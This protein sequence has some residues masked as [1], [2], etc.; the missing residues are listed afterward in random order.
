MRRLI[1]NADDLGINPSRD[2]GIFECIERGILTS[3]TLV[4]NGSGAL[5][6]A[7]RTRRMDFPTGLHLNFTEGFPLSKNAPS[8]LSGE[9]L[10]LDR[11]RFPRALE[12][13]EIDPRHVEWEFR[14]QMDWLLEHR[15]EATHLDSHHH[16]H[17]H[18]A[19]VQILAPLLPQYGIRFVR[20][21]EEPAPPDHV[22]LSAERLAALKRTA[23]DARAA[24][25][26]YS[27]HG[28]GSSDHFRGMAFAGNASKKAFRQLTRAIP[29]GITELGMHPGQV[30]PNGD[31]FSQDPQRE[32]ER[33]ILI[34]EEMPAYLAQ[35]KVVLVSYGDL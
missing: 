4:V 2:H 19:I 32:T 18:P 30:D 3:A 6:A 23:E 33:E 17:V 5:R 24:R 34:D 7:E 14:A 13:G 8:L 10:F 16:V 12:E 25:E 35:Q 11:T 27:A 21:P 22:P 20:I 31:P 1:L 26:L 9:G 29:E 15:G 28:V